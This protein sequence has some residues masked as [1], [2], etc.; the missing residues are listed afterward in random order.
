MIDP[1]PAAVAGVMAPPTPALIR[2]LRW[3]LRD[4]AWHSQSLS[5]LLAKGYFDCV[6][7]LPALARLASLEWFQ[8]FAFAFVERGC[9]PVLWLKA[10]DGR[11]R[12]LDGDARLVLLH[13][14]P[15]TNKAA[16]CLLEARDWQAWHNRFP[17]ARPYLLLWSYENTLARQD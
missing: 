2:A 5:G 11:K 8:H 9:E 13:A 12:V 7:D 16:I 10:A 17:D 6:Q 14:D 15:K 1:K 4:P 3:L